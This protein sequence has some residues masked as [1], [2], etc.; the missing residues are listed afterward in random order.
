[1]PAQLPLRLIREH[2]E[3]APRGAVGGNLVRVEPVPDRKPIEIVARLHARIA[4]R[5]IDAPRADAGRWSGGLRRSGSG[6]RH[7][8]FRRFDGW[9]GRSASGGDERCAGSGP[10]GFQHGGPIL[11]NDAGILVRGKLSGK[12]SGPLRRS[13]RLIPQRRQIATANINQPAMSA[14]PPTGGRKWI[15]R[16]APNAARYNEPENNTMPVTSAAPDQR[17]SCES[18]DR[19]TAPRPNNPSAL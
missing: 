11:E 10:Q 12:R 3:G 6:G 14:R 13:P 17:R 18:W 1:Q 4:A 15:G 19:R 16:G 7:G 8:G 9:G 5:Q 2:R